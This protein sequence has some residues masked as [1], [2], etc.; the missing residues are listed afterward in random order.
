MVLDT[1]PQPTMP[2]GVGHARIKVVGV[3]GA[4]V[5]ALRRMA[6]THV[7]GVEMLCVNT[8]AASLGKIEGVAIEVLGSATTRGLGAG[9]NPLIGRAAADESRDMLKR[10]L[11]GMDLVFIAAGM[12]GG[13]GTGAA[14]VVADIAR[15]LG[16]LT[17]AIVTLP[18]GFE[19]GRRKLNAESGLS[20]LRAAADCTIAVSNDKILGQIKKSTSANDAF[21]KADKIMVNAITAV[22]RVIN[23]AGDINVDFADIKATVERGGAGMVAVG[24]GTGTSRV[25]KAAQAAVT[26]PL[27]EK[28]AHGAKGVLYTVTAGPDLTLAEL[29]AQFDRLFARFDANHDGAVTRAELLT[30]RSVAIGTPLAQPDGKRGAK[31][32]RR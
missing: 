2:P 26:H 18:F 24:Q 13:T 1:Q 12:G 6:G 30:I 17:V 7:P 25:L 22:S 20:A 10:H 4:G 15:D 21:A 28:S 3:G 14:P 31:P 23:E 5:N 9:G 29:T 32:R 11:R 27:L 19:G 8:D 16:A